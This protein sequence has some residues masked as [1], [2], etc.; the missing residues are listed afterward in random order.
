MK[1]E[2]YKDIDG[3][4]GVAAYEIGE[5]FIRV[6]FKDN[7]VYLYTNQSAGSENIAKMKVLAETGD[8]LNSFINKYVR[9]NYA[10]KE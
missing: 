9:K 6:Q 4:S 7:A 3:D 10:R 8:G 2:K 1:M 5:D